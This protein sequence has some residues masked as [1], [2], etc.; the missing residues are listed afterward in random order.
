MCSKR[1]EPPTNPED[2]APVPPLPPVAATQDATTAL[3]LKAQWLPGRPDYQ[4]TWAQMQ[5][6]TATRDADSLDQIWLLEHDPVYTLGLA[7][8]PEH[9][10]NPGNIPIIKADRGGQ[11]T[12]HGPGQLVAYCMID[13]R[14]Y[15]LY[16][17]SYV[18]LLEKVI[19]DTLG[20]LGAHYA[21]LQPGAPGVYVPAKKTSLQGSIPDDELVKIAA[22]G[23]KIN[24]GCTYHGIAINIDMDLSPFAGINPCGYANLRTTDLA[25]C[26]IQTTLTEVGQQF[27]KRMQQALSNQLGATQRFIP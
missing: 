23:V 16:A 6:Y 19:V 21:Y 15:G 26:G 17:K 11:V 27:L 14:R 20:D 12:Y 13:L 1:P 22:L 2:A 7:G 8:R 24:K 5:Q 9:I 10:L 25:H 3:P 4:R 18:A